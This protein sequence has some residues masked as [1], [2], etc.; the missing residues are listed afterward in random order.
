M[1]KSEIIARYGIEAYERKQE[2]NRQWRKSHPEYHKEYMNEW[3]EQHIEYDKLYHDAHK[4][5]RND[6]HKQYWEDKKQPCVYAYTDLNG[7]LV[8]IGSTVNL[9]NREHIRRTSKGKTEPFAK[10]YQANPEQY[11]CHVLQYTDTIEEARE[12]E[13]RFISALNPRYNI[14]CRTN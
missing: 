7:Y 12:L 14:Q 5:E 2:Y 1:K 6:Y 3:R 10:I 8:Y 9:K 4:E 13:K 11:I